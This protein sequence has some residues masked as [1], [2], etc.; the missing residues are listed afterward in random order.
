MESKVRA[1]A[2][3]SLGSCSRP[4][5]E[6]RSP[7]RNLW[8]ARARALTWRKM[9]RSPPYQAAARASTPTTKPSQRRLKK[10][11][12]AQTG[13]MARN[14]VPTSRVLKL[15]KL[16]MGCYRLTVSISRQRAGSKGVV[17]FVGAAG[18]IMSP[19]AQHIR[20]EQ[21]VTAYGRFIKLS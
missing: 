9:N 8:A 15:E 18:L 19:A 5:R 13:A 12:S 16:I 7:S 20:D 6:V 11:M 14:T 21:G 4:E 3:I 1:K 10:Y 2:P 17:T